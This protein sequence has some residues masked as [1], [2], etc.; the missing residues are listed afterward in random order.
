MF[1]NIIHKQK[2]CV[3]MGW[4]LGPTMANIYFSC[5]EIKWLEQCPSEFKPV[6][7]RRYVDDIFV[8]FEWT[9]LLSK[10]Q[11]YVMHVILIFFLFEQKINGMLSF[12]DVE[13]LKFVPI[14]QNFMKNLISWNV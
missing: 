2:G 1:N 3:V 8:L 10:F 12:L 4:P 6:F 9:E 11:T 7:Y 13:V 14:G 5:Y